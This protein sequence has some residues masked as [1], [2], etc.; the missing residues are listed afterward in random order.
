MVVLVL[1]LRTYLLQT[2]LSCTK[3]SKYFY[4]NLT[5]SSQLLCVPLKPLQQSPWPSPCQGFA[6]IHSPCFCR[7]L[8]R[9]STRST[10]GSSGLACLVL[11]CLVQICT[12]VDLVAVVSTAHLGWAC[13][14]LAGAPWEAALGRNLRENAALAFLGDAHSYSCEWHAVLYFSWAVSWS[15]NFFEMEASC[16]FS[17]SQVLTETQSLC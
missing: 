11:H 7:Q 17:L 9:S 15:R 13:L 12:E 14:L 3:V 4:F 16:P 2:L 1:F 5:L 6:W 8:P 10:S